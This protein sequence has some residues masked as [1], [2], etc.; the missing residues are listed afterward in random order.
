[1]DIELQKNK[2]V[3]RKDAAN[4]ADGY[5]N[6]NDSSLPNKKRK[7]TL[8]W[9]L[10]FVLTIS[11]VVLGAL[12]YKEYQKG[13]NPNLDQEILVKDTLLK[14]SKHIVLPQTKPEVVFPITDVENLQKTQSFFLEAKNGNVLVVYS[15]PPQAIIYDPERDLIVKVGPVTFEQPK[16]E[17]PA[18]KAQSTKK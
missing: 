14:L 8:P 11:L 17:N 9:F 4:T 1:M 3:I 15:N 2:R 18:P 10:V 16:T 5:V 12:Y 7:N 6:T 13:I